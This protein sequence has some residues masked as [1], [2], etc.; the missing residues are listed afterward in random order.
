MS[1]QHASEHV[2]NGREEPRNTRKQ[3]RKSFGCKRL[4]KWKPLPRCLCSSICAFL[5]LSPSDF[6]AVIKLYIWIWNFKKGEMNS[7]QGAIWYT[8][9]SKWISLFLCPALLFYDTINWFPFAFSIIDPSGSGP[10]TLLIRFWCHWG[11]DAYHQ[12]SSNWGQNTVV[13]HFW[14][15]H[16]LAS[17]QNWDKKLD[18]DLMSVC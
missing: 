10:Q 3:Q 15:M 17:I 8:L 18:S 6:I 2:H 4:A 9:H 1:R 14:E 12:C 11:N 7:W 13:P 16:L 5:S